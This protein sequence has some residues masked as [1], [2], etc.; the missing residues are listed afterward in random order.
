ML[1]DVFQL[2]LRLLQGPEAPCRFQRGSRPAPSRPRGWRTSTPL[3]R[4]VR[5]RRRRRP[6]PR[7][8]AR[9]RGAEPRSAGHARA[10]G[11]AL[12]ASRRPSPAPPAPPTS[13]A[14]S[15][16]P[17]G[18]ENSALKMSFSLSSLQPSGDGPEGVEHARGERPYNSLT[19]KPRREREQEAWRRSWG[20]RDDGRDDF[21]AALQSNYNYL[22]DSQLI[23]SCKEASGELSWDEQDV[24]QQS[25]SLGEFAAQFSE[26]YSW[27]NRVQESALSMDEPVAGEGSRQGQLEELQRRWY[28]RRLFNEQGQ[29]LAQSLPESREE[30][31]RRLASLNSR[32]DVLEE[33]LRGGRDQLDPGLDMEQEVRR[34]RR[35]I[36]DME[37]RLQP[38]DLRT[39]LSWGPQELDEKAREHVVLQVD[40]ASHGKVVCSVVKLCE[41]VA[42][43]G[44]LRRDAAHALRLARSL[45][46]RWHHLYLRAIEW[47]CHIERLVDRLR[48]SS[49]GASVTDS[50]EEPLHKYPRLSGDVSSDHTDDGSYFE[51][52]LE[53]L[54]VMDPGCSSTPLTDEDCA[55]VGVAEVS[56]LE[57]CTPTR[58]RPNCGWFAIR[59]LDTDSEQDRGSAGLARALAPHVLNPVVAVSDESSGDEGWTYTGGGGCQEEEEAAQET[60]QQLVSQAELLV[61]PAPLAAVTSRDLE[62]L[63]FPVAAAAA[64]AKTRRVHAW[65]RQHQDAPA[66][67]QDSC[68]ASGEYTTGDSDEE[69]G[70]DTSEDHNG[71]VST[72][73]RLP[74]SAA[75][76]AEAFHDPD[77]TP[78]AEKPLPAMQHPSPDQPKVV[79]RCRRQL[80]SGERPWS[81]SGLSQLAGAAGPRDPLASLFSSESALHKLLAPAAEDAGAGSL[82][83]R[84]VRSRRRTLGRKSDSGSGGGSGGSGGSDTQQKKVDGVLTNGKASAFGRNKSGSFS[85]SPSMAGVGPLPAHS[86]SDPAAPVGST[87]GEEGEEGP[88]PRFKLGPAAGLVTVGPGAAL[89]EEQLSSFS[90]QA[91]DNYQE[92][93]MSEPYSEELAD[94]EAARRLLEFGDDYRNFLDSQSDCMSSLSTNHGT[95]SPVRRRRPT[96]VARPDSSLLNSDSDVEDVHHMARNSWSQLGFI[97]AALGE[98]LAKRDLVLP[99]DYAEIVAT[100]KEN[101]RCLRPILVDV[102][103][104]GS[105][106]T[107]QQCRDLRDMVTRWEGVQQRSESLHQAW[108][109]ERELAAVREHLAALASRL[110]DVGELEDRDQLHARIRHLETAMTQ[111]VETKSSLLQTNMAVHHFHMSLSGATDQQPALA[112]KDAVADLYK[113][114]DENYKRMSQHMS[115]LQ[116]A[117]DVWKQFDAQ[118][119]ELQAALRTDQ[120]TLRVLDS[121]LQGPGPCVDIAPSVLEVAKALSEKT[122]D[123]S[124]GLQGAEVLDEV[125]IASLSLRAGEG[126]GSLSDSGISDSGSEQEMSE[127]E[128]RLAVLRRLARNLEAVLS[129]GCTA[130]DNI[131]K[132]IEQSEQE[133]KTLQNTCRDLIFR[134]AL[135]GRAAG[136]P[137]PSCPPEDHLAS[138][139]AGKE[140]GAVPKGVAAPDADPEDPEGGRKFLRWLWR[141]VK[142]SFPF[143]V[144]LLALLC[145]VCLVE[146]RCCDAMNNFGLS[147]GPQLRYMRGP[148]PI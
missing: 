6:R 76:S 82:R 111:M 102:E 108:S 35:W 142:A 26:L 109:L 126:G 106:L 53:A 112:L 11:P 146:P 38:L 42:R 49:P 59:H 36:R 88:A 125:A 27:L 84:K 40:I 75:G 7:A 69:K 132:R 8:G 67:L 10:R 41:R 34:L 19:K 61:P 95:V 32:W 63:V 81:V 120:V 68:D 93:Y 107:P 25:W 148:P 131:L 86:A 137:A 98:L 143:Q 92:K 103:S 129:P 51:D 47:Q 9:R 21:W 97:E 64:G 55:M 23:D 122:E 66:Q 3:S 5:W 89:P 12:S 85:G 94:P 128:K 65:L 124:L 24:S 20:S 56:A 105:R 139:G 62:P 99:S 18:F 147:F 73:R 144:A 72:C 141:V 135:K 57:H 100:S 17:V 15:I 58:A 121:A 16:M 28:R 80:G 140:N 22:M 13:T 77:T 44:Q 31:A 60:I 145:F 14:P 30:V 33:A 118:L 138:N 119:A 45:E 130:L 136:G 83:R 114:W 96:A 74:R 4:L 70:S 39:G 101:L 1:L 71:S 113:V 78:V 127:R 133:L 54:S 37:A 117:A 46:R 91:W 104:K 29:Q 87:S 123:P 52:E 50:D 43:G 79:M 134:T 116:R 90:E 115:S 48:G 2:L 110:A